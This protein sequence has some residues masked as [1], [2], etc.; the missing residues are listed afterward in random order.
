MSTTS[1]DNLV[2][3]LTLERL[4]SYLAETGGSV[5]AAIRLY[6]WNAFVG[7]SLLADLG[8]LEVLF[9]NAVD[10]SLRE[11]GNSQNWPEPWHSRRALFKG[12]S[13]ARDLNDIIKAERAADKQR[14]SQGHHGKV[15]TELSF[16]FWRHLCGARYLTT[17]WVPAI[18]AAFPHH[19][20]PANPNRIRADVCDRMQ[21]LHYLRNRIAHHEP[22]HERN[23][24]RE[25]AEMLEIIRWIC[26]DSH[27][28]AKTASRTPAI[29]QERP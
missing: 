28:W 1:R 29:M 21:H 4:E 24:E 27:T 5:P 23:L 7:A 2:K 18:A 3:R 9:R 11:Y 15:L 12:R 8:R 6:D 20:D 19:P 26:P 17:L 16:G 10:Q 25:H 13:R 14:G 22:I